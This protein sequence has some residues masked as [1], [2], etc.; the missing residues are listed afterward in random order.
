M[1]Q[2]LYSFCEFSSGRCLRTRLI[3]EIFPVLVWQASSC[4]PK[5][6]I[7]FFFFF[8][9]IYVIYYFYSEIFS[10]LYFFELFVKWFAE[11]ELSCMETLSGFVSFA[12]FFFFFIWTCMVLV[13]LFLVFS[14]GKIGLTPPKLCIKYLCNSWRLKY[15]EV[16]TQS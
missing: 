1:I 7:H 8:F 11:W 9:F 3:L 5:M 13:L 4:N 10:F 2:L 15:I 12:F 16:L 14:L 6:F